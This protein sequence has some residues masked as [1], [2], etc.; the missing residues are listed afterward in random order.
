[1]AESINVERDEP[2][3]NLPIQLTSFVG[4]E[5]E[6]AAIRRLLTDE[7]R[8]LLTLTGVGGGGKTR[9]AIQV[10][11]DLLSEYPDGVWLVEFAS[12]ADPILAPKTVARSLGVDERP[13][14]PITE[15]LVAALRSRQLLLIL[16][17]IP[18]TIGR[19]GLS[20]VCSR[21]AG[22]APR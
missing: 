3:H 21:P 19:G 6:V 22:A 14:Q 17:N 4:R 2:Q 18:G 5:R 9:L 8:R 10:G 11:A 7:S 1:M 12:L 20:C 13:G 16:D 15:T